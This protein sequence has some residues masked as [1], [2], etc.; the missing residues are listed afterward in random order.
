M[1]STTPPPGALRVPEEKLALAGALGASAVALPAAVVAL[2]V[3]APALAVAGGALLV[4]VL[5]LAALPLYRLGSAA[6]NE[7]V[8]AMSMAALG[9]RVVL[10]LAAF[11]GLSFLTDVPMTAV[12]AGLASGLVGSITAEMLAAARDPRFFWV[13]T[14]RQRT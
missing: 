6:G 8:V 9:L 12:A 5:A 2:V 1:S 3:D 10:A 13:Q 14:E 4:A 7:M 11:A